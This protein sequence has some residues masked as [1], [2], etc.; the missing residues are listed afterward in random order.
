MQAAA[1]V[2][3]TMAPSGAT[4]EWQAA[5]AGSISQRMQ[6]NGPRLGKQTVV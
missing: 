1:G 3:S 2:Q 5:L 6:G 4:I